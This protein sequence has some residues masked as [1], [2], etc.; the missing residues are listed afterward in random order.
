MF[1]NVSNM[2]MTEQRKYISDMA[3]VAMNSFEGIG[4]ALIGIFLAFLTFYFFSLAITAIGSVQAL[5]ILATVFSLVGSLF[6][7]ILYSKE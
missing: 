3:D 1:L 2:T 6:F 4:Y 5:W 7:Q